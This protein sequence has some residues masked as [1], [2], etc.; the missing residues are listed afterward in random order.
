MTAPK[1][2]TV[3]LPGFPGFYESELSQAVDW[4]GDQW[5]E[6]HSD[7]NGETGPDYE[8]TYPAALTLANELGE[9]LFR[10]TDY[11]AAYQSLARTWADA[12]DHEA[13]QILGMTVP[14]KRRRWTGEGFVT[15]PWDRPSIGARFESMDSPREY[16][17]TTDRLFVDVPLK[18]LRAMFRK[19]AEGRHEALANIIRERHASRS[20]FH[21]FYSVDLTRW[22]SKPLRDW[23]HNELGTLILAALE[24][25]GADLSR[26]EYYRGFWADVRETCLDGETAS[27]A[28]DSAVDWAALDRERAE[29]RVAKLATWLRDDG[30]AAR[31]WIIAH[32]DHV[33]E[34]REHASGALESVL[35][36]GATRCAETLDM[37]ADAA[38]EA[39]Q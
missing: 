22:L 34:M 29:M 32:P 33:D 27:H 5:C 14:D 11:R 30:E 12:F 13:G 4:E 9:L 17:F 16:N 37:F 39:G 18:T 28:F 6:Y 35:F 25:A 23:D 15:E 36:S 38:R 10:H 21:S 8:S 20:G 3:C 31:A 7:D 2:L 19:S 24:T 1:M 26:G